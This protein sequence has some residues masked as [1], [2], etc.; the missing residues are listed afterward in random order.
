LNAQGFEV[1]RFWNCDV[2]DNLDGVL[3][4]IGLAVGFGGN[5]EGKGA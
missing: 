1:L 2:F 5:R 4:A 3:E